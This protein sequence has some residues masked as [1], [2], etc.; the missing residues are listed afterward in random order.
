MSLIID[1]LIIVAAIAA[2]YLGIQRGFVKSIMHFAS[3]ILA[4][5]A[6]FVFTEPVKVWLN[7]NFIG[8]RVSSITE[9]SLNGIVDAGVEHLKLE[10][11]IEDRPDA[12]LDVTERFSVDIEDFVSYY[13][14]FLIDLTESI[15]IDELAEKL[16][17]PTA[18]ALSTVLAA[19][20][21]FVVAMVALKLITWLLDLICRLPVLD[22][23]NTFLGF[24][25]GVAS[26]VVT[27]LVISNMAVGLISALESV[28]G[29]IFNM[30]VIE[31]SIILRFL[32][33]NSLI[34]FG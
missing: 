18:A 19:I 24:L 23:L 16:A 22:K 27:S 10:K 29:D 17:D 4:L 26:A 1:A 5:I 6:V 32:H 34:F 12:L 30:G 31:G 15:A 7:D 14:E 9:E 2:V 33:D 21:V 3:L 28:N 25:F 13:R 8:D 11:V 20:I